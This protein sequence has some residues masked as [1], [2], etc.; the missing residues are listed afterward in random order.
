MGR[1]VGRVRRGCVS[2]EG[3]KGRL[4][5]GKDLTVSILAVLLPYE[6]TNAMPGWR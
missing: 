2:F 4:E 5:G 3:V 1:R 6:G